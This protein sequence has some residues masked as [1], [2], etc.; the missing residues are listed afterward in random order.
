[1]ESD[2]IGLK[3]GLNTYLFADARPIS[4]FDYFGLEACPPPGRCHYLCYGV[5]GYP[6][7][8]CNRIECKGDTC[9]TTNTL[10]AELRKPRAFAASSQA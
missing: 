2:P 5:P 7:V 8:T 1:M 4:K 3:G 10:V 6:L 9:K